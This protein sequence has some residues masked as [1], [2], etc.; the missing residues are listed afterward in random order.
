MVTLSLSLQTLTWQ[1]VSLPESVSGLGYLTVTTAG[2]NIILC[3]SGRSNGPRGTSGGGQEVPRFG[4]STTKVGHWL[5]IYGGSAAVDGQQP[6]DRLD[7]LNLGAHSSLSARA[8]RAST[9]DRSHTRR[10]GG[11]RQRA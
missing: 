5:F 8:R 1:K 9:V 11:V 7:L 2:A 3:G 6:S 10:R 4:H